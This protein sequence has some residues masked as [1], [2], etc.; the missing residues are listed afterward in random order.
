MLQ[1]WQTDPATDVVLLTWRRSATRAVRPAG[2]Q[3]RPQQAGGGGRSGRRSGGPGGRHAATGRRGRRAGPVRADRRDPGAERHP[4][5]RRGPAAGVPAAAGGRPR[6][7][8]RQLDGAEPAGGRRAARRG[9]GARRRGGR[10]RDRR[11]AR[12]S[13]ARPS[14]PP[15]PPATWTRWWSCSSRRSRCPAG[16]TRRR[17][18]RRWPGWTSPWSPRSS[19][20][21]GCPRGSPDPG[22]EASRRAA[23]CPSYP[24]PERAVA[25][26]GRVARYAR[27]RT[28]P[29]GS[30]YDRPES[31]CRALGRW[32]SRPASLGERA[33][34][35]AGDRWP[36][37]ER[38]ALLTATAS[39]C[40]RS[41]AATAAA[42]VAAARELGFPVAI[43]AVAERWQHRAD[44]AGVRLSV[45]THQGARQAFTVSPVP[46]AATRC[47]SSAWAARHRCAFAVR[48][49][50]V[51]RLAA[52]VRPVRHGQRAARRPRLPGAAAVHRRRR[53]P[54][55]GTARGPLLAG[56][57]G[58][59]AG[60]WTRSRTS[61]CG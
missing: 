6:R 34:P 2:P 3:A 22:P 56:Y 11:W 16:R 37:C 53:G 20:P 21:R 43:K 13:S 4:D 23:R 29:V 19:A 50:P 57:R 60:T 31:T 32:S 46:R 9:S 41:A 14:R 61:R 59:P 49:R 52:V 42:T 54:R 26:L 1:Y 58:A 55:P 25:A 44:G 47:T 28:A 40:C 38:V 18:A 39:T 10:R 35:R 48:R 15:G 5:V 45:V 30:T 24:T 36:T 8:G 51:V 7:G 27:W 12:P 17:C 33:R